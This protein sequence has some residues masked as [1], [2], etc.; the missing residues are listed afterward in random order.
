MSEHDTTSS[1]A[2]NPDAFGTPAGTDRPAATGPGLTFEPADTQPVTAVPSLT[3]PT[4]PDRYALADDPAGGPTSGPTSGPGG[5][6]VG[7]AAVATADTPA[8]TRRPVRVRTVVFGLVLLAISVVSL[9]ALLTDVRVD[10]GVVGVSLLIGAG[11]ALVTGGV[12]A[13]VR[14]AKGGPGAAR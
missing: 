7:A 4:L 10:G 13:A 12:A 14:E 2:A 1:G 9:V 11:I 6:P 8:R 3:Y 5:D